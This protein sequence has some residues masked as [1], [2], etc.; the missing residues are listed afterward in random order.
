[1]SQLSD[2]LETDYGT[3]ILEE[4]IGESLT[5]KGQPVRLFDQTAKSAEA[6][7]PSDE[8]GKA[9][10]QNFQEARRWYPLTAWME[11]HD[12]DWKTAVEELAL[13]YLGEVA[14]SGK[15]SH[16]AR[17]RP[18]LVPVFKAP[19]N[20]HDPALVTATLGN[21]ECNNIAIYLRRLL[22]T[23]NA[24]ELLSRFR[25]GTCPEGIAPEW[26]RSTIYW[27]IDE[28][29]RVHCG[30]IV[31]HSPATGRR[32][33]EKGS[34]FD[35]VFWWHDVRAMRD[36]NL[37]Q[38]FYGLHQIAT[39]P[40]TKPIAL[41][42]S[43]KTAIIATAFEPG[44]IWLACGGLSQLHADKFKPLAGRQIVL[45]PDLGGFSQWQAKADELKRIGCQ[46]IVSKA[47]EGRATSLERYDG[48]DIADF[49][50][51]YRCPHSGRVL[52][53]VDGYPSLWDCEPQNPVPTIKPI[54]LTDY[55]NR[56]DK[57]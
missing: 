38:C 28:Q 27:Q 54:S 23:P 25:V 7:Y 36:F 17:P 34:D 48:L 57:F 49:L 8:Q 20:Y 4:L 31:Y 10:V 24:D 37:V 16:K 15:R 5:R 44:F 50:T 18:A 35:R 29:G 46:I 39:Q 41:V 47:L 19:P 52:N 40:I 12:L 1:M 14:L 6:Y 2:Q 11:A 9:Y 51:R 21:Y 13:R 3:A 26:R 33:K 43:E 56:N 30:K 22:G 42:E 53:E 45:F 55:L 32:M